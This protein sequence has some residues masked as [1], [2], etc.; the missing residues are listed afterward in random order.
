MLV[1][2]ALL[3]ARREPILMKELN[4]RFCYLVLIASLMSCSPKLDSAV[5]QGN[6][7]NQFEKYHFEFG[8]SDWSIAESYTIF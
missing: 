7:S 5:S 3:E 1:G 8:S 2:Q 6:D 4:R